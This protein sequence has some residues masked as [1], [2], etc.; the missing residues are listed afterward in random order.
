M[1]VSANEGRDPRKLV[2]I[3]LCRVP[4]N[5]CEAKVSPNEGRAPRKLVFIGLCRMPPNWCEVKVSANESRDPRKLV[6]IGLY[7]M[8]P[9][10][11]EVKVSA[12]ESRD[13]VTF[14]ICHFPNF[15]SSLP[16]VFFPLTL[17]PYLWSRIGERGLSRASFFWFSGRYGPYC[18]FCGPYCTNFC[19]YA[20]KFQAYTRSS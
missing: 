16:F 13:H 4:P 18:S 14:C 7:R 10:W 19:P 3:G 15:T 17:K 11:C 6:F 5:W 12:N 2:F 20:R 1:K 8:P 9:N